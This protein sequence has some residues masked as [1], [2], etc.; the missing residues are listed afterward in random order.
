MT[1]AVELW[2]RVLQVKAL[3]L[4]K[5][6]YLGSVT[7]IPAPYYKVIQKVVEKFVWGGQPHK[8]GRCQMRLPK[9]EGGINLWDIESKIRAL[10]AAWVHKCLTGKLSGSLKELFNE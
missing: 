10:Q 2:H 5:I 7:P 3:I 9:G 4:S 8:I 6:W 1:V